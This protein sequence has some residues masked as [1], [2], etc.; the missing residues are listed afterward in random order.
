MNRTGTLLLEFNPN[1]NQLR[2]DK[3]LWDGLSAVAQVGDTLW[4]ANDEALSLEQLFRRDETSN[5]DIRYASHRQFPLRDF[6]ELPTPPEE[7]DKIE[8]ADIEGLDHDG[9]YLWLVGSH[10]LKRDKPKQENSTEKNAERLAKVSR[11]GN[12]FLLARIP[13]SDD[14]TPSLERTVGQN[15]H[16]RTAARLAGNQK[17]NALTRALAGDEHLGPFLAI[18]SKDNGFDIEGLAV[19]GHRVFVGLRGPVLRGWAVILELALEEQ[20]ASTLMLKPIGPDGRPYRKH[21]LDLG[22]LGVRDLCAQGDDLLVLAGPTMT[23][24]GPQK[25]FR[26]SGGARPGGE[27]LIF[28]K[29]LSTVLELPGGADRQAGQDQAEGMT[30]FAPTGG[31]ARQIL[32]VYDST[33]QGRRREPSAVEADLFALA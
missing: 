26:W 25:V 17:T 19:A 32:V 24:A 30:L 15:G 23:V 20:D 4:V 21:F 12:R 22:G 14:A 11:D 9:G 18:P 27:S 7:D 3:K 28:G 8:E 2:K 29:D 1:L 31:A 16:S 13:L 10:S 33:A 5:G 6:L